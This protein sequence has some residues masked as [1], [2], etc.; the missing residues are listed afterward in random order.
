MTVTLTNQAK[1][2][3]IALSGG[4][5]FFGWLFLFTRTIPASGPQ[6]TNAAVHSA[7]VANQSKHSATLTNVA[8]H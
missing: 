7:T 5:V 6:L 2:R 3:Q 8:K 1:Y 4:E